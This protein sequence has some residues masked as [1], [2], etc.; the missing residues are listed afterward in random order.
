MSQKG[1]PRDRWGDLPSVM[2]S[3]ARYK[4]PTD[5]VSSKVAMKEPS[6]F[7][8]EAFKEIKSVISYPTS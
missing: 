6:T 7:I 4:T 3:Q 8:L 5:A 1:E 2:V